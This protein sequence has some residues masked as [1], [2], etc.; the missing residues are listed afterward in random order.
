MIGNLIA[1]LGRRAV[2]RMDA[3]RG[4]C[5][6]LGETFM[7]AL[8]MLFRPR[9]FR[10]GDF[11]LA[12]ERACSDGLPITI[13]IGFLLGLILAFESAAA[14]QRFGAEVYVADMIA[15]GLFRELGP[16]ITAVVLAG[17]TGSAFAAEI[18]TMKVDE[19]LDAL[20][21]F[22]LPPVRF[23]ALPRIAAATLAMPV[24]TIC[25]ELAGLIGGA[26]VL[27]LMGVPL[28]V[29][30]DHVCNVSTVFMISFGLAKGALFGL[31]VGFIGCLA[32]MQTKSTADGVG[33]AATSAVVGGIVAIAVSDGILAVI[34]YVWNV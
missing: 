23:L 32:G 28:S 18:G 9:R 10:F 24:L 20:T 1:G 27:Q 29:S 15:I 19:E 13:L 3:F 12:F 5:A 4:A 25:A 30:W 21:T 22:G 34:C 7:E 14:L 6:F 31:L 8:G 17:R 2:E 16:L 11:A 33:V 26:I